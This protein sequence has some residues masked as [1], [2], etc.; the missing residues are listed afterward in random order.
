[1]KDASLNLFSGQKR[2]L[3]VL[4]KERFSFV[5]ICTNLKNQTEMRCGALQCVNIKWLE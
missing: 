2:R 5:A 3:P 1:M 4:T